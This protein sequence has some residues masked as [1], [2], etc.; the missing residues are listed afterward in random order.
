VRG[1]SDLERG[2]NTR[3]RSYT[4]QQ[5]SQALAL[6]PQDRAILEEAAKACCS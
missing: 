2:I 1:I 3:P 4:V 5:L 6:S